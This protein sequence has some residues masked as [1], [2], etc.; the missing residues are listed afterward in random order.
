MNR[1]EKLSKWKVIVL[2]ALVL[3]YFAFDKIVLSPQRQAESDGS[4]TLSWTAPTE[5]EDNSPLADLAGY[6]IHYGTQAGQYSNTIYVDD[7]ET[8]SYEVENLMPGTYYFAVTA[9]NSDGGESAFSNMVEKKIPL[10]TGSGET[11]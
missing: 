5:N 3:G 8:T 2:A 10:T 9:I 11:P 4:V 1:L 7:P 6:K